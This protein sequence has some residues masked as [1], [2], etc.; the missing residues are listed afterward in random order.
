[1]NKEK[2]IE[3]CTGYLS[4]EINNNL[5]NNIKTLIVYIS[6]NKSKWELI[7][8][9]KNVT[10]I[11]LTDGKIWGEIKRFLEDYEE[12]VVEE[13]RPKIYYEIENYLK[14]RIKLKRREL[15][16]IANRMGYDTK[17]ERKEGNLC[18]LNGVIVTVIPHHD[19]GIG[20]CINILKSLREGKPNIKFRGQE[21]RQ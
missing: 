19:F 12:I 13:K 20:T 5:L 17:E 10:V 2:L 9:W 21:T 8:F 18:K 15:I 7:S 11:S 1:M 14:N 4:K 16:S 3:L 6:D